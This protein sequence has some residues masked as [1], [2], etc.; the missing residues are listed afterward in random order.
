MGAKSKGDNDGALPRVGPQAFKLKNLH[1]SCFEHSKRCTVFRCEVNCLRTRISIYRVY[2]ANKDSCF[3][4]KL[5]RPTAT[6][7]HESK[8]HQKLIKPQV[9]CYGQANIASESSTPESKQDEFLDEYCCNYSSKGVL[10]APIVTVGRVF[11][12]VLS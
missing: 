3:V 11:L 1:P 4:E 9:S 10:M 6:V 2:L 8:E 5:V 7:G 12:V